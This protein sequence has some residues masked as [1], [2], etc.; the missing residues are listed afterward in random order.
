MT[1]LRLVLG[2]QLSHSISSL[3]DSHPQADIILMMEVMEE[4]TYVRHHQQKLVFVFSAMRHFAEELRE[5]GFKVDYVKLD[6][7]DNSGSFSG[8]LL[9][10]MGRH[11][12]QRVVVTEPSE[13]RVWESMTKL[14][15][16]LPVPIEIREDSR[17][18]ASREYFAEWSKDRKSLRMEY[19]YRELRR[20]TGLLMQGNEP[21]GGTWN[22]DQENRKSLP[23]KTTPPARL[24]F[25]QDVITQEV[26]G[27]VKS[28]FGHHFG[29]IEPFRWAV[30]R[31]RA[32]LA[33]DHFISECLPSFG[34]YQD[35]MR[36]G[37]DF[38]FHSLIS[39]Y[40]NIGLLVAK[41]VCE[42]A[43]AAHNNGSAP[44][45]SVEGFVRQI[46]GWRE[47]VRGIYW[48]QMP[49]YKETNALSA[50]RNLPELFWTARTEL[51]CLHQV[52]DVTKRTGYAHHIQRLMI[53]GNFALLAG[54]EPAQVEEWYL[55]VYLDAYEW[56]ELPNVHG[57]VLFADDGLLASKPY[58]ASG[59]YIDRMSDYCASCKYDPKIKSGPKA[60]PFNP[61]YWNFLIENEQRLSNNPRMAMP[62][63]NLA[64]MS[65]DRR[66][67]IV[68][69][70]NTFLQV[71]N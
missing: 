51:N 55:L 57:M 48:T 42:R 20:K 33:L 9:R 3:V 5:R 23:A 17:F 40:L 64:K 29:N 8:E 69:D 26:I 56:V 28:R 36:Q 22:Y 2:D 62:Y 21:V 39:P 15:Q 30:T 50:M 35:A 25:E 12:P 45:N 63:R 61:L 66:K 24:G 68:S 32:L 58:A 10:A 43:E 14:R 18:F 70:A 53:T 27:L 71:L 41:E 47:Y 7:P 6:E 13:W 31:Q 49:A 38:L 19:F 11:S 60:C 44:I 52:I 59:A 65:L 4:A 67:E 54:I 34:D 46:L 16:T 37:E 1:T